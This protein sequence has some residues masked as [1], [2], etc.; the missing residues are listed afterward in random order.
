MIGGDPVVYATVTEPGTHEL[1][2]AGETVSLTVEEAPVDTEIPTPDGPEEEAHTEKE[3]EVESITTET[4]VGDTETEFGE[5]TETQVEEE[6][7][8]SAESAD[9]GDDNNSPVGNVANTVTKVI[10]S[11]IKSVFDSVLG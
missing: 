3:T 5:E 11:V 8:R 4:A 7:E 10:D 9:G 6:S 1:T 2:V